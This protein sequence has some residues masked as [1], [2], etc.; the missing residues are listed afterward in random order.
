MGGCKAKPSLPALGTAGTIVIEEKYCNKKGCFVFRYTLKRTPTHFEG[1]ADYHQSQLKEIRVTV[2][3]TIS[4]S[5]VQ[6][7]LDLLGTS[8]L[9]LKVYEPTKD[10]MEPW[11]LNISVQLEEGTISFIAR[12][13]NCDTWTVNWSGNKYSIQEATPCDAYKILEPY[14]PVEFS[15]TGLAPTDTPQP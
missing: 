4:L 15:D 5:V 14:L 8:R 12:N 11:E 3:I 7:F 10:P 6:S 1:L 9:S 13:Y 2:P